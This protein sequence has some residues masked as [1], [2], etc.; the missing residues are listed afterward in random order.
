MT[1]ENQ[2]QSEPIEK[3]RPWVGVILSLFVSGASQFFLGNRF[4]GMAWFF[5][6]FFLSMVSVWCLASPF[7]P[8]DFFAFAVWIVSLLLWIVMLV[9]S[10]RPVPRFR[11]FGWVLL[12]L[13]A[14]LIH[15]AAYHGF[16]TFFRAMKIPTA[17]MSPTLF[18]NRKLPDGTKISGDRVFVE[19]YAYWFNKPQRGD[20]IV[21]GASGV[22]EGQREQWHLPPDESY[23]KRV[24]GVP[25]DVLSVKNGHLYN[26]GKILSEP[27]SL[28]RLDFSGQQFPSQLYLKDTTGDYTIP[29]GHYFVVGDN[30]TNSLDSRYYGTIFGKAIVGKVSKI[31]WPLQRAGKIE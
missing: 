10:Y 27:E 18:G 13:L 28:V 8:G 14:L 3:Y 21:F 11:W 16:R 26:H 5:G 22:W 23:V 4:R 6:L 7:V 30:I 12:I 15:Q 2:N 29:D 31:Y 17:A 9:K 24:I 25:G 1:N 20:V 19:T